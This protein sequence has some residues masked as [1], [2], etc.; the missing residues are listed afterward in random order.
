MYE[1]DY[2]QHHSFTHSKKPIGGNTPIS[3]LTGMA[4]KAEIDLT[5]ETAGAKAEAEAIRDKRAIIFM[6]ESEILLME[7][8]RNR[9]PTASTVSDAKGSGHGDIQTTS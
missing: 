2:L 1:R 4:D 8:D 7:A 6:V 3:S 9:D 5:F